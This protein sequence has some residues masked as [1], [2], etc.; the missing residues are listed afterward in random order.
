MQ[1]GIVMAIRWV[2]GPMLVAS[3]GLTGCEPQSKTP[4]Q[5]PYVERLETPDWCQPGA[6]RMRCTAEDGKVLLLR[7]RTYDEMQRELFGA[8]VGADDPPRKDVIY[9]FD[10]DKEGLEKASLEEWEA[11][12]FHLET[13]DLKQTRRVPQRFTIHPVR[14]T[15]DF[16]KQ[17]VAT[18]GN[19]LV[20]VAKSPSSNRLMALTTVVKKKEGFGFGTRIQRGYLGSFFHNTI[21]SKTGEVIGETSI[22]M[23]FEKGTELVTGAW[24]VGDRYIVYAD[25]QLRFLFLIDVEKLEKGEG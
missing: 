19:H 1:R 8:K 9:R 3:V 24:S 13:W 11:A 7:R 22:R 25:A 15:L 4:E 18:T 5:S 12:P 6:L 20:Y 14:H 23:P 16:K 2:C 17:P 21:D 10:P